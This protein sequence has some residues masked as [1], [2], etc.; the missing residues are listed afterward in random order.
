[1]LVSPDAELPVAVGEP[2]AFRAEAVAIRAQPVDETTVPPT[3]VEPDV[4]TWPVPEVDLASASDCVVVDG[5]DADEL[6]AALADAS[7]ATQ[8]Q[9]D[10]ELFTLQVRPLL[11]GATGCDGS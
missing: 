7:T 3:S 8:F 1:M 9:Q 10:G 11:P 2:A 4:Q 5:A 6:L